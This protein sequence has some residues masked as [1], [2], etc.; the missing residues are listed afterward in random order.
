MSY[1]RVIQPL[2]IEDEQE[3]KEYY[4]EVFRQLAERHHVLPPW[5]AFCHADAIAQLNQERIVHLVI[6]DLRLP[7]QPGQPAPVSLDFGQALLQACLNREDYPIP[8]MLVISGNLQHADQQ[9]LGKQVQDGFSYGRVLV[10]S[11]DL[12]HP[13]EDAVSH[14]ERYCDVGIHVHDAGNKVFPTVSPREMD[15]LRRCVVTGEQRI[16]LDLSWWSADFNPW[17]GWTKVLMGRFLLDQGR[18]HSLYTFFKLATEQGAGTV[19]RE[20]E[21][22]RQKLKHVKVIHAQ[23]AGER[24]LLVTQAAGSGEVPP[25]SFDDVLQKD[26]ALLSTSLPSIAETIARQ[27]YSLGDRTPDQR[28]ISDLLWKHHEQEHIKEQWQKRGGPT[29]LEDL[30][31]LGMKCPDPVAVFEQL[32]SNKT[33]LRYDNQSCLHGDLNYT[34]VALEIGPGADVTASIFDASG[35]IGGVSVRDFAM[36]EVTALLHQTR[37]TEVSL[38]RRC[39]ALYLA[40][41][42]GSQSMP[43]D[44]ADNQARNTYCLVSEIRKLAIQNSTSVLYAL[45]VFDNALIQLGGLGFGSSFNKIDEPTDA[46]LLAALTARWLSDLAPDFNIVSVI[47]T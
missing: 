16:G 15:L 34:N 13:I 44:A 38:V 5:F 14:A 28:K 6:L 9:A 8:A 10:K 17:S 26:S 27:V 47:N 33:V 32:R 43:P 24:S 12:L 39:E 21:V 3:P 18:G 45:M 31:D 19:F 30:A 46:A 4:E 1:P 29:M 11:D 41:D 2:V 42:E 22:M 35:C 36:F 23:A 25:L 7:D 40:T 20:A 37:Q